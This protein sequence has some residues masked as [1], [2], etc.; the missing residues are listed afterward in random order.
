MFMPSVALLTRQL[1]KVAIALS[2]PEHLP[3]NLI[4]GYEDGSL[5]LLDLT[6]AEG[7]A[8]SARACTM[9]RLDVSPTSPAVVKSGTLAVVAAIRFVKH[10]AETVSSPVKVKGKKRKSAAAVE[11]SGPRWTA[12]IDLFA[13][14]QGGALEHA[15]T[16]LL[17]GADVLDVAFDL[18]S[19]FATVLG[20]STHM[21]TALT[22]QAPTAAFRRSASTAQ[23]RCSPSSRCSSAA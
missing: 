6:G 16:A 3:E 5:S 13:V 9:M 2:A 8:S 20:A 12:E 17:P 21:A 10:V 19:G 23:A 15:S 22:A 14:V 1:P 4:V 11:T 18:A 7:A